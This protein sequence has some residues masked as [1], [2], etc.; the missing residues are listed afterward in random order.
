MLVG[1]LMGHSNIL[2]AWSIPYDSLYGKANELC[3]NAIIGTPELQTWAVGL[4]WCYT[5][6][7]A[8][9]RDIL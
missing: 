4:G 9:I 7:Y 1:L 3:D 2:L 6:V 5:I 8:R